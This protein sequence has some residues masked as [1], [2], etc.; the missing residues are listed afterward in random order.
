MKEIIE[1]LVSKHTLNL[2]KC[3]TLEDYAK[4]ENNFTNELLKAIN[5][6]HCCK[7]VKGVQVPT[8]DEFITKF[9]LKADRDNE[10]FFD[11]EYHSFEALYYKYAEYYG[12]NP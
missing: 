10:Y 6:S 3:K 7:S 8:F 9:S 12:I 2:G 11:N 5:Y 4:A 1:K